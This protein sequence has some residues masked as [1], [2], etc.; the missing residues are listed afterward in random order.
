MNMCMDGM[1]MKEQIDEKHP[2]YATESS[3]SSGSPTTTSVT[4]LVRKLDTTT[5]VGGQGQGLPAAAPLSSGSTATDP[6]PKRRTSGNETPV[7]TM[8]N[9]NYGGGCV[10]KMDQNRESI[11]GDSLSKIFDVYLW[12][13]SDMIPPTIIATGEANSPPILSPTI[14]MNVYAKPERFSMN[15]SGKGMD[16]DDNETTAHDNPMFP[17]QESFM[18]ELMVIED[19]AA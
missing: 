7:R 18:G 16:I 1:M 17:S 10:G 2:I 19:V 15:S 13:P 11:S 9:G 6:L 8:M 5:K 4:G 12:Q 14:E 3:S